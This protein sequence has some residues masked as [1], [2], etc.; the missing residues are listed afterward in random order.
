[1]REAR[2]TEHQRHAEADG[3]D[4]VLHEVA[5]AHD[6]LAGLGGVGHRVGGGQILGGLGGGFRVGRRGRGCVRRGDGGVLGGSTQLGLDLDRLGE[7]RLGAEAEVPQHHEGHERR[8]AQQQAGLDDL[9][10]GGGCHA[11][12]QHV[13]H[14][15]RADDD[16]GDVVLQAEQQL[17]QLAR[18]HHLGD[19]V[20]GHHDERARG[21]E[22]A[23]RLLLEAEGSHVGEGELAQ[24]AQALGHQESD[25]RP[26]DQEADGVDQAIKTRSHH[27][28]GNAQERGGRHV[29]ARDGQTVL[30]AGDAA[31]GGVEVGGALGLGGGP[32]GDEE[33]GHHEQ[34][35]HDDRGPVG[36]LFLS[37]TEVGAGRQGGGRDGKQR[38]ERQGWAHQGADVHWC[39][40][41]MMAWDRSSNSLLA[42]RT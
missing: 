25:D 38:G 14:H 42:R 36:G 34:R 31:T 32:L 33:R 30:E 21:R 12:E 27:G 23:D 20:E 5:R 22:D 3:G 40:S 18:A 26:A 15:Q 9:H 16:H 6:G 19:Q 35:E 28:R 7:H 29:V 41:V 13:D 24:V 2:G 37:L 8:A 17:D 39:T 10:P 1:M 11:A 4:R